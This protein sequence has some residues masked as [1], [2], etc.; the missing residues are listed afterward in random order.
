[1]LEPSKAECEFKRKGLGASE[2][3]QREAVSQRARE[4]IRVRADG[5]CKRSLP[6]I[7]LLKV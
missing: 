1:M 6:E 2:E 4:T 7:K 3:Q 5:R